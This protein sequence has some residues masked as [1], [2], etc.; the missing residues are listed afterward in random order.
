[1]LKDIPRKPNG[2]KFMSWLNFK[3]WYN[4]P[5]PLHKRIRLMVVLQGILRWESCYFG[6]VLP[7]F[8]MRDFGGDA[9]ITDPTK[10]YQYMNKENTFGGQLEIVNFAL[11]FKRR[12]RIVNV[13]AN[14]ATETNILV[15]RD[16][17]M[18]VALKF[19]GEGKDGTGGHYEPIVQLQ[20]TAG[21]PLVVLRTEDQ[22]TK[23][24]Y[25]P[26]E[27]DQ[28]AK[29]LT[30]NSGRFCGTVL[31]DVPQQSTFYEAF[32]I[33]IGDE[34]TLYR[35]AASN[36]LILV[37]RIIAAHLCVKAHEYGMTYKTENINETFCSNIMKNNKKVNE[38][39][40]AATSNAFR[41][42]V[43]ILN[44]TNETRSVF[45]CKDEVR[46]V[47]ICIIASNYSS[48]IKLHDKNDMPN[49][50]VIK[51]VTSPEPKV[52]LQDLRCIMD[53]KEYYTLLMGDTIKLYKLPDNRSYIPIRCPSVLITDIR[54]TFTRAI[55][56]WLLRGGAILPLR[57]LPRTPIKPKDLRPT[58]KNKDDEDSAVIPDID[59]EIISDNE[60]SLNEDN[61]DDFEDP[62][63]LFQFPYKPDGGADLPVRIGNTRQ[64]EHIILKRASYKLYNASRANTFMWAAT[65][66]GE[67]PATA[68]P[69]RFGSPDNRCKYCGARFWSA[70]MNQTT[71]YGGDADTRSLCCCCGKNGVL[72]TT[73]DS[74]AHFRE[75]KKP[76]LDLYKGGSVQARNF[77]RYIRHY[78]AVFALLHPTVKREVK[79]P[80]VGTVY[81]NGQLMFQN[82]YCNRS[83]PN[84]RRSTAAIYFT[85]ITEAVEKRKYFADY[86]NALRTDTLTLLENYIRQH[87]G[88]YSILKTAREIYEHQQ[89]AAIRNNKKPKDVCVV[90]NPRPSNVY[91]GMDRTDFVKFIREDGTALMVPSGSAVVA[92]FQ[93]ISPAITYDYVFKMSEEFEQN[94][95]L[96]PMRKD[97]ALVDVL[98]YPLFHLH[99]EDPY[100]HTPHQERAQAVLNTE[101][102]DVFEPFPDKFTRFSKLYTYRLMIRDSFN[103]L[104]WGRRLFQEY[105][106]QA[107][108]RLEEELLNF[109]QFNQPRIF[110]DTRGDVQRALQN[111][112]E[113]EQKEAGRIILLTK[114]VQGSRRHMRHCFNIATAISRELG[115]PAFFFTMILDDQ[116]EEIMNELS[117]IGQRSEYRFFRPDLLSRSMQMRI[118]QFFNYI[119]RY[120]V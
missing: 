5:T 83:G 23:T 79:G 97:R 29:T 89:Q 90:Y 105:I 94:Q 113:E 119:L 88:Y 71:Q 9:C 63:Q 11:L 33:A 91:K 6:A 59:M 66:R 40:Y 92:L 93:N 39:V 46:Q 12:V 74:H 111:I 78:N 48:I 52:F 103:P 64:P 112:A 58:N 51:P 20:D 98:V 35:E 43:N 15:S 57:V 34:E 36:V 81:F 14:T 17:H 27:K 38:I 107:A 50:S 95:I 42:T 73:M 110:A 32:L 8:M 2:S 84:L 69:P 62:N 41:T 100:F 80:L 75:P 13:N 72:H 104:I 21:L 54:H 53:R 37:R 102:D 31:K 30:V 47:D 45:R 86:M 56:Y 109:F 26:T 10:Y 60:S 1:M 99:G 65:C 61:L 101:T 82:N 68:K 19:S 22:C 77:Q 106:I 76:I 24:S 55:Y 96:R 49:F 70:E 67:N 44:V 18:W 7:D 120:Q 4:R 3:N 85:D 115:D 16:N 116:N 114:R 87:N 108:I 25:T 117:R 28:Q 118:D